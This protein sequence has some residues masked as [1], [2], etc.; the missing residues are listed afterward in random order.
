[1]IVN[2]LEPVLLD[3]IAGAVDGIAREL[4]V[5]ARYRDGLRFWSLRGCH[6]EETFA[7]G[8]SGRLPER[9]HRK[10]FYSMPSGHA[11]LGP[12]LVGRDPIA[13]RPEGQRFRRFG[14]ALC[15]DG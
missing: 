10:V 14:L 4:G 13:S 9:Q 11:T 12:Q 8:L 5:L 7:E 15:V 3:V 1:L 6:L 2:G